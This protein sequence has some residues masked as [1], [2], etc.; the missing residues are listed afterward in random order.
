MCVFKRARAAEEI[1]RCLESACG[2]HDLEHRFCRFHGESMDT[3]HQAIEVAR[4]GTGVPYYSLPLI[5]GVV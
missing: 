3:Q 5:L 4:S 2:E 1:V